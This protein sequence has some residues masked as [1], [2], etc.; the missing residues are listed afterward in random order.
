[1][2]NGNYQKMKLISLEIYDGIKCL[3]ENKF[4]HDKNNK[5]SFLPQK[6]QKNDWIKEFQN[7]VKCKILILLSF[8]YV[9]SQLKLLLLLRLKKCNVL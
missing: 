4:E 3:I 7:I 8:D 6:R 5:T 9:K 2:E 1:M